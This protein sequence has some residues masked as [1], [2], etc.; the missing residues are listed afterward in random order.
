MRLIVFF[1]KDILI[2][3]DV[4]GHYERSGRRILKLVTLS[5]RFIPDKDYYFS[6]RLQFIDSRIFVHMDV[7]FTPKSPKVGHVWN[8]SVSKCDQSLPTVSFD[9]LMVID[10]NH[11]F[12]C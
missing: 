10:V 6:F 11:C 3:S 12:Y 8:C 5:T 7:G 9:W 2:E 1:G 4:T